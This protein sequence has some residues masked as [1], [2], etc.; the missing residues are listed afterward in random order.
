MKI[1]MQMKFVEVE[2]ASQTPINK[3]TMAE[4]DKV[5]LMT[6]QGHQEGSFGEGCTGYPG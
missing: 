6:Y 2:V 5:E 4:N 1:K 3:S